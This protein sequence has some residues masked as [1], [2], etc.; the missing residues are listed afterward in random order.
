VILRHL[1][2]RRTIWLPT[3]LGW[4]LLL[5]LF[6]SLVS[7]WLFKGE[8]F[9]SRTKRSPAEVL[10]VEGWIG[11]EGIHAA[12]AEFIQ[13]KYA[14]IVT[15]NGLTNNRWDRDQFNYA[16]LASEQLLQMGIAR[17][18]VIVAPPLETEGHRT[19]QS[20]A[21]VWRALRDK[22]IHPT[23]INVFT[24]GTHARRSQLVY[25]KVFAPEVEVG[26]ISWV[27]AGYTQ[28]RWWH[29]SDRAVEMIRET[30]GFSFELLLNSG[31]RS[32]S[33][34]IAAPLG[35]LTRIRLDARAICK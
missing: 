1:V 18:R 10:V 9:L 24:F 26:V 35:S 20:A 5:S 27:P 22:D 14:Y 19:F 30:V 6:S 8:A 16:S 4:A 31:R 33:P 13:G 17:D 23:A 2:G 11:I 3:L 21:A 12:G 25:S 34:S 7:L 28:K 29:S 32:N 15:T